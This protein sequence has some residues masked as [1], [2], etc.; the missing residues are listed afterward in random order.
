MLADV[1]GEPVTV[2]LTVLYSRQPDPAAMKAAGSGSRSG[3]RRRVF[4]A[5]RT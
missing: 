2:A 5:H 4:A 1:G 3:A